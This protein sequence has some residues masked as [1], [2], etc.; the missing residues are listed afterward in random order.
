LHGQF[1]DGNALNYAFDLVLHSGIQLPPDGSGFQWVVIEYVF[2]SQSLTFFSREL[3]ESD[4]K[5]Y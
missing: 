4:S 2:I 3:V 5:S 1:I